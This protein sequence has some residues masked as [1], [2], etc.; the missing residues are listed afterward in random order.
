M[1]TGYREPYRS[2]IFNIFNLMYFQS[3]ASA[4]MLNRG[5]IDVS[6]VRVGR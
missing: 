1:Y 2:N 5:A 3:D 4:L 6:C